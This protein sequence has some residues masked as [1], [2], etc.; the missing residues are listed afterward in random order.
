MGAATQMLRDARIEGLRAVRPEGVHLTLKFLG[1]VPGS[2]VDEIGHALSE[3]VAGHRRF[4]V[5]TGGFGAFPNTRRPQ[6]LWVGLAGRL[7][8]LMGLQAD[9]DAALVGLGFPA[10]KRPFH[11]HLTLA[12]LDRRM[13]AEARRASLDALEATGLPAVRMPVRSVSLVQSILGRGG[14][15]YV[16]L[17]TVRLAEGLS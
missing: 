6:V 5:S 8:P 17:F 13:S 3:A 9:V 11:P 7:E 15:T 4:E 10:E 2:R 16:R 1:D 14:A 12:R